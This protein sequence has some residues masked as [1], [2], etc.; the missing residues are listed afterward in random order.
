MAGIDIKLAKE[1]IDNYFKLVPKVKIFLD[2]LGNYGI[3][4]GVSYTFYPIF[5]PR[6]YHIEDIENNYSKLGEI[7]RAAKNAPI[8]GTNADL[9]KIAI[10]KIDRFIKDWDYPA[11]IVLQ[12]HDEIVS[13]V[14]EDKAEEFKDIQ[15]RLMKEAASLTIKSIP[16]EIST[17]INDYW[18][19]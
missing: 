1:T 18:V 6:F 15:V 14:R 11:K 16:V 7:E 17:N 12:V 19:K 2:S 8:Q 13:E 9:L 10:L 4:N 5:R 3:R